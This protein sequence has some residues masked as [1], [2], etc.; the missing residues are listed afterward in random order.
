MAT[1]T[2]HGGLK[3]VKK[4]F[5][6]VIE[7]VLLNAYLLEKDLEPE[8]HDP[9]VRGRRKRDFLDFCLDV[10]EQL[11]GSHTLHLR[12]GHPLLDTADS[13]TPQLDTSLQQ[14]PEKDSKK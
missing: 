9:S 7:C 10:A 13:T 1:T 3:I 6:Y 2:L 11:I 14:Y 12:S 8:V 5:S 4:S